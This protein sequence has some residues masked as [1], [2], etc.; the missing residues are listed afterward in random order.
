[1]K[2]MKNKQ[3]IR[4]LVMCLYRTVVRTKRLAGIFR[5]IFRTS[6]FGSSRGGAGVSDKGFASMELA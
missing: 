1:M 4:K 3:L 6:N 2:I 5:Y